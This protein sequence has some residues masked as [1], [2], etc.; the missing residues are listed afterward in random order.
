[1]RIAIGVMRI[2]I[3]VMRTISVMRIG[4]SVMRI[5]RGLPLVGP[6]YSMYTNP[7]ASLTY[8]VEYYSSHVLARTRVMR[9]LM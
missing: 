2:A 3:R 7:N 5:D 9:I 6:L 4:I 8:L 1:M